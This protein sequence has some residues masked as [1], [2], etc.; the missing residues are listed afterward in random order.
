MMRQRAAERG[1]EVGF[2]F[3]E[4]FVRIVRTRRPVATPKE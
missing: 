4:A 1:K 3:A 2:E